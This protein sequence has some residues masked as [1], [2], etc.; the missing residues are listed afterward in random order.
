MIK[1]FRRH[2][3]IYVLLLSVFA[4]FLVMQSPVDYSMSDARGNLLTAQAML[5]H[6]SIKLDAYQHHP[7][8]SHRYELKQGHYYYYFPVGT[9]VFS[10]PFV[11]LA[12]LRG[13]HMLE[14]ADDSQT[15]RE[16]A[17]VIVAAV[18]LLI[19]ATARCYLSSVASVTITFVAVFGSSLISVMGTALWNFNFTTLFLCATLLLIARYDSGKSDTL[20]PYALGALLFAA[21]LC[22]PTSAF[23]IASI[24][25]YVLLRKPSAFIRLA[26]IAGLLLL[27]FVAFSW[28]EYGQLLPDYYLLGQRGRVSSGLRSLLFALYANTL[29]PSRGLFVFSPFW[30]MPLLA[31]LLWLRPLRFKQ[32]SLWWLCLLWFSLHMLSVSRLVHWWA[33]YSYGQRLLTDALPALVMLSIGGWYQLRQGLGKRGRTLVASAWLLLGAWAIFVHS[34]QGLYNTYTAAWNLRPNIDLFP[35]QVFDWRYPQFLASNSQLAARIIN[36][37]LP[38]LHPYQL[39]TAIQADSE[40]VLFAHWFDPEQS[41]NGM[42]RWSNGRQSH[43]LFRPTTLPAVSEQLELSLRLSTFQGPHRVSLQLNDQHLGHLTFRS[44]NETQSL[45]FDRSLLT[46]DSLHQ[47]RLGLPGLRFAEPYNAAQRNIAL[48]FHEMRISPVP[49]YVGLQNAFGQRQAF[50]DTALRFDPSGVIVDFATPQQGRMLALQLDP[51]SYDMYY[52]RAGERLA[53]QTFN[54]PL[55]QHTPGWLLAHIPSDVRS[56]DRLLLRPRGVEDVYHLRGL[57][58]YSWLR[59]PEVGSEQQ[60]A[61]LLAYVRAEDSRGHFDQWFGLERSAL[62]DFRWSSG[63]VSRVHFKINQALPAQEVWLELRVGAFAGTQA[64]SLVLNGQSIAELNI[65]TP[66]Y[67]S[68]RLDSSQLRLGKNTL[69]FLI[70]QAISPMELGQSASDSR[71]LGVSFEYLRVAVLDNS[72]LLIQ[73]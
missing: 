72:R 45:R 5:E 48:A 62:R 16:I 23:F 3:Y 15:Q 61:R 29:S 68:L 7:N 65:S 6:G 47:L 26:L 64:V 31:V 57:E 22:R 9:P 18:L 11:W 49:A 60:L 39:G 63:E 10:V 17:A 42:F 13:R 46:A 24:M 52:F 34:H 8:F 25:L 20:H 67:H 59:N 58:L 14:A 36:H 41:S 12:N 4:W 54:F 21:F 27:G 28:Q 33:G 56:F 71:V 50:G 32:Q 73:P 40:E 1:H 44:A 38:G 30:L 53:Q 43:V 55:R 37:R 2:E 69:E 51:G 19:Y 35:R 66:D 70:P